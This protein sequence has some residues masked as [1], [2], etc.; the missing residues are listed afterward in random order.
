MTCE[1][2]LE[3]TLRDLVDT[4]DELAALESR[5]LSLECERDL[6]VE[7]LDSTICERDNFRDAAQH[8][9][10]GVGY[11]RRQL[12]DLGHGYDSSGT[13]SV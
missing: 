2:E 13:D 11:L 6:L 12:E 8:F 4:Q 3:L 7:K 9:E 5:V 1:T 10:A